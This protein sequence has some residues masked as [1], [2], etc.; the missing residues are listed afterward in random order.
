MADIK[1][2]VADGGVKRHPVYGTFSAS[3]PKSQ[4]SGNSTPETAKKTAPVEKKNSFRKTMSTS[5]TDECM[6]NTVGV[7]DPELLQKLDSIPRTITR[8]VRPSISD[9]LVPTRG[10]PSAYVDSSGVI[11][12]GR[13]LTD[14][15]LAADYQLVE[16]A[17]KN[18]DV[19]G[20]FHV[21]Y[22]L[23][24]VLVLNHFKALNSM[25]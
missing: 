8:E 21:V 17:K 18:M 23:L 5:Q 7:T 3:P 9:E 13:L 14:E 1:K 12:Y 11:N 25:F 24:I 2:L 22:V 15:V 20:M 16:A 6:K 19:A 4:N 10:P